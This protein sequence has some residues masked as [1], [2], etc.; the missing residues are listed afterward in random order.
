MVICTK[1]GQEADEGETFCG[2]CGAFLQWTGAPATPA[3]VPPP[4]MPAAASRRPVSSKPGH[5]GPPVVS[6]PSAPSVRV[7]PGGQA[8]ITVEVRNRG[9][10]VDQLRLEVLGPA[11]AWST[12][13]P[14]RLNLMPDTSAVA[15]IAFRPPRTSAVPAGEYPV[16]VAIRSSQHPDGSVVERV[17]VEVA[18]FVAFETTLAPSV[19]RGAEATATLLNATNGGNVTVDLALGGDDPEKAVS[20]GINPP[21]LRVNPGATADALVVVKPREPLQSGPD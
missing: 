18:P 10:T 17:T 9:R 21:T 15:T 14:P 13:E 8:S 6:T 5:A 19:L 3:E 16:D 4:V 2:G 7:E 1:C 11:A 12:V 20:F